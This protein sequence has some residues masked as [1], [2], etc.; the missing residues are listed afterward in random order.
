[1]KEHQDGNFRHSGEA[2]EEPFPFYGWED[3]YS[4]GLPPIPA[5]HTPTGDYRGLFRVANAIGAGLLLYYLSEPFFTWLLVWLVGGG[6]LPVPTGPVMAG[7]GVGLSALSFSAALSLILWLAPIPAGAAFPLKR[8]A[9]SLTVACVGCGM[10]ATVLGVFISGWVNS[11]FQEVVGLTPTMPEIVPPSADPAVLFIRVLSIAVIPAIFEELVFRGAIL[12]CLR[13]F[14]ES[15][16]LLVS[17]LLFAMAH[18]N[19][20]QGPNAFVLGLV[21][22]F[23]VLR[24]GSLMPAMIFHF[25]NNSA[26]ALLG[27]LFEGMPAERAAAVNYGYLILCLAMGIA[28]IGVMWFYPGSLS[29][30]LYRGGLSAVKRGAL[31]FFAPA[32]I[33]FAVMT[34]IATM[35]WF[36]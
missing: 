33:L 27:V 13:R 32:V 5:E 36:A 4:P 16:A 30:R 17:A 3:A 15:F 25:I 18:R 31:F 34:V 9:A 35:S 29:P 20:V 1:V 24:A 22:G 21:M 19:L 2:G 26:A 7:L 11:L 28:G 6:L 23:F 12:Q 8:P 10:G 14:G